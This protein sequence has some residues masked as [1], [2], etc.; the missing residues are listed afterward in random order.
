MLVLLGVIVAFVF[1][2]IMIRK[3][4]NFGISLIIGS[5][6]LGLFSLE[7]IT[8]LDIPKAI[9]E[10][11]IYSFST[12]QI[13]TD[14]IEL[15]ILT[16]LI[17]ILARALQETGSI[18]KLIKSLRRFFSQGG[19][20]AVI[21]SVYGLMPVPG[22]ALLSAPMIDEEGEKYQL[23]K[24]QKNF[25]N[26]WFRHIWESMFPVYPAMILITSAQFSNINIYTLA[27]VNLPA[28]LAALFIGWYFLRKFIK[29]APLQ[30][31]EQSPSNHGLIFLVPPLVPLIVYFPMILIGLSQT[32]AFL[33]GIIVSIIVLF[34]LTKLRLKEYL[35]VLKKSLTWRI[36]MAIF[37]IM[38][39]R[40][41]FEVTT[42][43]TIVANLITGL[44]FSALA[45]IIL[46]PVVI[47]FLIGY[48]LGA[49]ALSYF[50]V[51]PF[52]DV[53]GLSILWTTSIVFVSALVGYLVSPIHL[54]NVLSGEYLK[55]DTTR[56]YKQFIPSAIIVLI[57]Q[58]LFVV[59]VSGFV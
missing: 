58:V 54:C 30:K 16:T 50:L 28:Y 33:I 42:A 55:T 7:T 2:I 5:M 23:T 6:I 27:V 13:I 51:Q 4:I 15:A 36:A 19:I 20:L 29:H 35:V 22:G 24:N 43:N 53:T 25:L 49:I 11:L 9:V 37:G 8:L 3:K 26:I 32:R 18:N 31:S 45:I 46:I 34:F 14:T 1:I 48:N 38:I 12:Q 17:F 41:M 52:F 57:V 40:Q 10:A 59:L 21:P 44:P 47:G 39:F 56:I